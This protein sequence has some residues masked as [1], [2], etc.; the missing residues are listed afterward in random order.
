MTMPGGGPAGK[1][2][3]VLPPLVLHVFPTF[4]VGGAQVRFAALANRFGA[5]WRHAIVAMDGRFGCA[6]RL[7][8]AIA[9]L[10][11]PAPVANGA[12]PLSSV[13]ALRRALREIAPDV[14]VTSNW[15]S[16][17][18]AL[19]NLA[20]P[21]RHHIHTEDGFGPEE[22]HGQI[23][24][25]VWTRRLGLRFSTVV[26]PSTVLLDV[27][28]NTWRLPEA[29]LRYIPNGLDIG[30][31]TPEGAAAPLDVPGEGP[32]IGTV[33]ALRAEKNIARLLEACAILAGAGEKFRLVVIGDGAER[34]MLEARAAEL[35]LVSRVR[36]AGHVPDPAAAYRAMD[37]FALSSDTE[38][39]PF[40]VLEAMATALPVAA[41]NVGDVRVMLPEISR[42]HVA[43]RTPEAL[44]AA[45]RPLL[46]SE[47]L[48][49]RLGAA[50]RAKAVQDYD[51]E[52][53]FQAYAALIDGA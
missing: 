4:A 18:W 13:W 23:P 36:F 14:L 51:Q 30:R 44:A 50:N 42:P 32:L 7:D 5:R 24:R 8:P 20:P 2:P 15:G 6:E 43:A 29:R 39:M 22:A 41:T 46:E 21:R 28:R 33:A 27:A 25:R 40:S 35:G 47:E 1:A 12:N 53:M 48:R 26:L 10:L 38:Q 52:T 17:E 16:I 49:A 3:L 45:L 19:A 37:L 34:A 9:P 31:F 11:L